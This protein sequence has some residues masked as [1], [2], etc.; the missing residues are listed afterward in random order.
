VL[1]VEEFLVRSG[2]EFNLG[3]VAK[4]VGVVST[5]L[6]Q[7]IRKLEKL[8]WI[9]VERR[10]RVIVS[11][12]PLT[13]S[14][15]SPNATKAKTRR[16]PRRAPE[17]PEP[18]SGARLERESSAPGRAPHPI[19]LQ[20]FEIPDRTLRSQARPEDEEKAN[21]SPPPPTAPPPPL[22]IQRAAA[23][24][25]Q[26]NRPDLSDEEV[27]SFKA[28]SKGASI[29][30]HASPGFEALCV[31]L[32][33]NNELERRQAVARMAQLKPAP[34]PSLTPVAPPTV[35]S[36]PVGPAPSS[37][38]L[39]ASTGLSCVA[40]GIGTEDLLRRLLVRGA[41]AETAS[42]A[43]ARLAEVHGDERSL[44]GY[45]AVCREVLAGDL[46]LTPV[47]AAFRQAGKP[48]VRKRGAVFMFALTEHRPKSRD[49]SG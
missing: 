31:L 7:I 27:A 43:A 18:T 41:T 8:G 6:Y 25:C 13:T 22:A 33:W 21:D 16:A 28:A 14:E 46:R 9:E 12:R 42:I 17:D 2:Q 34:E 24:P 40:P 38:P 15:P 20:T 32:D 48:G 26:W 49:V 4:G 47:L 1:Q 36:P 35:F 29:R 11:A 30:N 37:A 5:S 23:E 19:S 39:P 10:G 45:L 3:R 44:R